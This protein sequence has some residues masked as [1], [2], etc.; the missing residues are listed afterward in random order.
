VG[1]TFAPTR[2]RMML[3]PTRD[4]PRAPTAADRLTE[5]GA[6]IR[7]AQER[8]GFAQASAGEVPEATAA[9][10]CSAFSGRTQGVGGG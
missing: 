10:R 7:S 3:Q 9:R 4:L 6:S 2:I 5:D 8:E 1:S